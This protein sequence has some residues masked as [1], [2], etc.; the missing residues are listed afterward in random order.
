MEGMEE[1]V[2]YLG[3]S[4][5]IRPR[6]SEVLQTLTEMLVPEA[7]KNTKLM[8]RIVYDSKYV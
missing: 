8:K 1:F 3:V 7:T 2:L 5:E 6:D 4:R